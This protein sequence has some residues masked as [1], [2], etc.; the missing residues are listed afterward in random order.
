[1]GIRPFPL[2]ADVVRQTALPPVFQLDDLSP[3]RLD[4][5]AE[6]REQ[7]RDFLIGGTRIGDD[8]YLV[9]PQNDSPPRA[10]GIEFPKRL[11]LSDIPHPGKVNASEQIRPG[12][13]ATRAVPSIPCSI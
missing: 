5:V 13:R 11:R 12:P 1:D 7:G 9:R 4:L 8:Q 10:L 3:D 6:L 2:L